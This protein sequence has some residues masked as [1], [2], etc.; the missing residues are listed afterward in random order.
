M[1]IP[2]VNKDFIPVFEEAPG[3]PEDAPRTLLV[4]EG[5]AQDAGSPSPDTLFFRFRK[6]VPDYNG[7]L[8]L[9]Q[10]PQSPEPISAVRTRRGYW[11]R[12]CILSWLSKDGLPNNLGI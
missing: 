2:H 7:L 1:V 4:S 10:D 6:L 8:N 5:V 11:N 3:V 12:A 9:P